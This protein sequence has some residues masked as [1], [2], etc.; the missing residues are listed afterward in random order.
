MRL[1]NNDKVIKDI[2]ITTNIINTKG[3]NG[4]LKLVIPILLVFMFLLFHW[5]KGFYKKQLQKRG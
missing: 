4:K 5:F 3:T 1:I 2:S